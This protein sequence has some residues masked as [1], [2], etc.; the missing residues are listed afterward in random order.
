MWSCEAIEP[1]YRQNCF[2]AFKDFERAGSENRILSV[3]H[4]EMLE[5]LTASAVRAL[6]RQSGQH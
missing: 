2:I 5:N 6:N 4:P 1:Y 3:I